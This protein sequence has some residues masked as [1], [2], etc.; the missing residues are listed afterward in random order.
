M[1]YQG[2]LGRMDAMAFN[3]IF[4]NLAG[5]HIE[6]GE[7]DS[8]A[9]DI[10]V[11]SGVTD[12]ALRMYY[13]DL[14]VKMV[15]KKDKSR[16]LLDRVKSMILDGPIL[17]SRNPPDEGPLRIGEVTYQREEE[18]GFFRFLWR[19]ILNGMRTSAGM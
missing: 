17:N 7:I 13:H 12:G 1:H 19:P 4:T 15:D 8:L 5:L 3:G 14:K 16:S 18:D 2:R 6:K 11:R 9:F 10:G